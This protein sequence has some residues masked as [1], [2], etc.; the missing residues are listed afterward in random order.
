MS[1]IIAEA[2]AMQARL[3]VAQQE[4]LA[5]T[6]EGVAGNGLVKATIDGTG[7]AIALNISPE[8]VDPSDLDTLQDLVLGALSDAHQKLAKL[9]EEKMGP[10]AQGM[11]SLGGIF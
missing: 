7:K 9:A 5:S 11:D 10:L 3:Q 6:V 8:V 1:Q 2:Q 4:I